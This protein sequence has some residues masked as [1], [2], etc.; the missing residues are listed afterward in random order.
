VREIVTD[1]NLWLNVVL[2]AHPSHIFAQALVADCLASGVEMIA[3]AWWQAEAD[4]ALRGMV[5]GALL[6]PDAAQAAQRLLDAAPVAVVYEPA[7][8]VLAR[9]IS[10]AAKRHEVYDATYAALAVV[11][12]CTLWTADKRFYN[13]MQNEARGAYPVKLVD[14]YAGE[15]GPKEDEQPEAF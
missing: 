5:K 10:D 13:A 8:R 2:P 9:Q 3:P 1:A 6:T 15:Y 12:G 14:A 11:S 7:M 4:S